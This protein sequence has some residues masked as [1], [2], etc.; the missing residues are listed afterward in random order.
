MSK[1]VPF[2]IT[3]GLP[4]SKTIEVTLPNGRTWWIDNTEFEVLSQIREGE[5]DTTP[6]LLDIAQYMTL[7]WT[8]PDSA[9][10][11]L[12]MS[13]AETRLLKKSGYY[14]VILSDPLPTDVRAI[15]ILGGPVVRESLVT[16]D[17]ALV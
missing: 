6:L 13:G 7:T 8:A 3:S 10:I 2:H 15:K 9:S 11:L 16:S 12:E 5:D 14:D 17:T 4:F 1:Q